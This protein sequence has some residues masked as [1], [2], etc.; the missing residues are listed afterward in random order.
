MIVVTNSNGTALTVVPTPVYQGSTLGGNLYLLS[1]YGGQ[2]PIT[3][4]FTLPNGVQ[5]DIFPMTSVATVDEMPEELIGKFNI[6]AYEYD[7]PSI[8]ANAGEVTCQFTFYETRRINGV[9]KLMPIATSSVI[10]TVQKGVEPVIDENTAPTDQ[11]EQLLEA[12]GGLSGRITDVEEQLPALKNFTI[13]QMGVIEKTFTDKSVSQSQLP[14]FEVMDGNSPGIKIY[15]FTS[16]FWSFYESRWY[17]ALDGLN[18]DNTDKYL[19][20]IQEKSEDG[21][22]FRSITTYASIQATGDGLGTMTISSDLPFNGRVVFFSGLNINKF[23][24][25]IDYNENTNLIQVKNGDGTVKSIEVSNIYD[26]VFTSDGRLVLRFLDY[27]GYV[28]KEETICTFINENNKLKIKNNNGFVFDYA[29]F[30]TV[31]TRISQNASDIAK[32]TSDIAKNTSNINGLR[33][34]FGTVFELTQ[35]NSAK[36][37]ANATAIAGL[38]ADVTDR[39]H[40]RGYYATTGEVQAIQ[41]PKIGDYCYNAETGTKWVYD[42]TSGINGWKNTNTLVPDQTIP[43]ATTVPLMD[44]E[45]AQIGNSNEYAAADHVHPRD[46]VLQ[47]EIAQLERDLQNNYS[48]FIDLRL[49][50]QETAYTVSQNTTA[51]AQNTADIEELK[52]GGTSAGIPIEK[53]GF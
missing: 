35:E 20:I 28:R 23:V 2:T 3:V 13:N 10:F 52:Q 39:E 49:A 47:G 38:Q 45:V 9:D 25:S 19:Y 30:S 44:G 15:N 51:I 16:D 22:E 48:D 17:K 21:T 7:E 8:T 26:V 31:Y 5:T 40:F 11:W 4:A 34:D 43:K 42:G 53:V 37:T 46:S 12:F 14:N 36:T 50:Y 33:A 1:P 32:N 6:W 24:E 29:D 41:N 27:D 18:F